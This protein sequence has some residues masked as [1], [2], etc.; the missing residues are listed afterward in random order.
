[1]FSAGKC[2]SSLIEINLGKLD[3]ALSNDFSSMFG[4]CK[5]LEKLDVSY[6]NTN[7]SKSFNCMF[8]GCSKLKEIN[9]SKFKTTN[10]EK[11]N[12]IF[13]GCSLESIDML[14]WDMKNIN[15]IDNYI[16]LIKIYFKIIKQ[17]FF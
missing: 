17:N 3:F 11:I 9:V 2:T 5:N 14:N 16:L 6:F 7:N 13:S 12:S 10:C 1:M 15:R 8:C 4:G